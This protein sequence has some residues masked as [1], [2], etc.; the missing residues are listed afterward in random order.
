MKRINIKPDEQLILRDGRPFG[1]SGNFGG[2]SY[3]WPQPQTI[4]GMIR[5]AIGY[6][7]DP[8][9]FKEQKN[10]EAV[11]QISISKLIPATSQS[12]ENPWLAPLPADLVFTGTAE[13]LAA[14]TLSY[15]PLPAGAGSDIQNPDWL[16]PKLETRE[17]PA[18]ERPFMLHW[19][20]LLHYLQNKPLS[21]AP[22]EQ[23]GIKPLP[24]SERIHNGLTEDTLTTEEGKLFM[25][26]GIYPVFKTLSGTLQPIHISCAI[27]G[28]AETEQLPESAHLG[29][30]RKTVTLQKNGTAYPEFPGQNFNNNFLKLFLLTPGD[31]GDW[32]PAWLKPDLSADKIAWVTVPGT[33]LKVRLRSASISGWDGISGWDYPT[34]KP[35]AMRKLVKPG[36][37]YLIETEPGKTAETARELWGRSLCRDSN[38]AADGYGEAVIAA[39]ELHGTV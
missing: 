8:G 17:K 39:A 12:E 30:E 32:C 11:K 19:E 15:G 13:K 10:I 4:A 16:Y 37:V 34:K 9:Y 22:L 31:F 29:G 2:T 6:S 25:N 33:G 1:G 23:F 14:H 5:T 28:L 35:K 26:R 3:D 20:I 27:N 24:V 36:A 7:R 21:A 38:A 18:K